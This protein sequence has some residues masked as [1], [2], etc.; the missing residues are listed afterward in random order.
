MTT[1]TVSPS[2]SVPAPPV[3]LLPV[4]ICT[5]P[6]PRFEWRGA[7]HDAF[8]ILVTEGPYTTDTVRWDSGVVESADNHLAAS[9]ELPSSTTLYAH[10]RLRNTVGWGEWSSRRAA[11]FRIEPVP[12]PEGVIHWFSLRD[13]RTLS[14]Q[15]QWDRVHLTAA[16]Q[17]IVNRDGSRLWIDY[18]DTAETRRS[19]NVDAWWL[20]RLREPGA[21]L[22]RKELVTVPD[23]PSLLALFRDRVKGLVVWDPE[24]P[25]TSNVASTIAGADDL[26]PVRYDPSPGSLYS[27]LTSGDDPLPVIV[28]LTGFFTG[29]GTIPGTGR[30]STGSR[31]CDA[32]LWAVEHYVKTGKCD[33]RTMGY[34]I[35]A[36]W[37]THPHGSRL[38]QNHTLT[39]HDYFIARRGFFWDLSPWGDEVPVDDPGQ[40]Q[41][42]DLETLKEI[43]AAAYARLDG[44]EFIHVGG[45][46]P[47]AFKY[48][49]HGKAGGTRDGVQT[50]WETVRVL[51]AYNAFIDADALDLSALANASAMM[52]MPLPR[53]YA[54]P[55]PPTEED[56]RASR[57]LDANGRPAPRTYL[58]HYVGDYDSAAWVG[59]S[60]FAL[61]DSPERGT[62]T[63]P[64]AINPN[65]SD[66]MRPF[67]EYAFRTRTA[68]D[69]FMAGDSGAGYVNPSQLLPPRDPSGLP[70][71]V[72]AWQSHCRRYYQRFG[73]TVT[74][75]LINGRAG[76]ISAEA[77]RMYLPF[78]P[79]GVVNQ[80]G[81]SH[82]SVH[83][84]DGRLP[85]WVMGSDLSGNLERDMATVHALAET[86][87][88]RPARFLVF[89]TILRPVSYIA[90]LNA[91]LVRTRPDLDYTFCDPG[92]FARLTR[93]HFGGDNTDIATWLFDTAPETMHAGREYGF[94]VAVRNDGWNT[95]RAGSG[96]ED[97]SAHR[98]A[99]GFSPEEI[100][101]E[102]FSRVA[103]PRDVP[104]GDSV[105]LRVRLTVPERPG[106]YYLFQDMTHGPDWFSAR[107]GSPAFR[108][109]TVVEGSEG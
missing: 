22:S 37:I 67:F 45:F 51:S 35:D 24:V 96:A 41:G 107:G 33:P 92:T 79:D 83:L 106:T 101:S 82:A 86:T 80:Y 93:A 76:L 56:L 77:E 13:T 61:W 34:Y 42:T 26:L 9:S 32:Y 31:K 85:V 15:A 104:P 14:P 27:E 39:N 55:P 109:V 20:S 7:E 108:A 36:W 3:V 66:R 89:R 30:P 57:L 81:L 10:V 1:S 4:G 49:N 64:W 103:L 90:A 2:P 70:G 18:V 87:E 25:A 43:L 38:A 54:Q 29:S 94:E 50:E 78:S 75:F 74:G 68:R 12:T 91:E 71:A 65:L 53:R 98:A 8:Q 23:L 72:E 6:T 62:V 11:V 102:R 95:W 19:V 44:R 21:W 47:W 48:T 60:L 46:T 99:V 5:G 84:E 58:L 100:R 40:K 17:G 69:H 88:P 63:M 59:N 28:N 52:H 97:A 105:V 16:L 73:Y